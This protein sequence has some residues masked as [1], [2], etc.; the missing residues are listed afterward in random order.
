[1]FRGVGV[2]YAVAIAVSTEGNTRHHVGKGLLLAVMAAW[3]VLIVAAGRDRLLPAAWMAADLAVAVALLGATRLVDTHEAVT[4]GAPTLPS[5]WVTA[6]VLVIATTVGARMGASA[7]VL[8][9]VA[10]VVVRG[11]VRW[12]TVNNGILVVM[13]GGIIGYLARIA[14]RAEADLAYASATAAAQSERERLGREIHDSVLQA[15]A[16]IVRRGREIGG[17]ATELAEL[18]S[19]E[20]ESLRRLVTTPLSVAT[21]EH[22]DL[23]P[24][25]SVFASPRVHVSA[26]VEPV[27]LPTKAASDIRAAVKAALDNVERHAGSSAETFILVESEADQVVVSVRDTGT[28]FSAER[29]DAAERAGRMGIAQSIRGRIEALGGTVTLTSGDEEGTEVELH[30]PRR[31]R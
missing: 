20:E 22:T 16:F 14:L 26:P 15:L 11:S 17:D 25:L 31:S 2:V 27:W 13:V 4:S 3:S 29:L 12:V 28:G 30:V 9:A 24:L 6:P 1:M 8:I 5:I 18:A 7:G 10:G 21:A 23:T 19:H